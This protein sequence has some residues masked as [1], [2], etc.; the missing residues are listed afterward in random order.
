MPMLLEATDIVRHFPVTRGVILAREIGAVH[1]LDGVSFSLAAGKTLGLVGESGSGK[2]TAAKVVL[3]L[4]ELTSGRIRF[5]GIDIA[6]LDRRAMRKLRARMQIVFQDPYES[7]NPRMRVG[8]IV[9]EPLLV[10]NA[11][12][13]TGLSGAE[14]RSRTL[15]LLRQVGLDAEFAIRYPHQLSSGQRQRVG[16][17]RALAPGPKLVVCDEPVSALDVSIQAQILDLLQRLQAELGLA[18]LFISHDL[19]VV[20]QIA[21][22][23]AVMYLGKVVEDGD[24]ASVYR[25]PNHPYTQ[26]LLSAVPIPDPLAKRGG[27][28]ILLR[29]EI[30]S[31]TQPPSGCRF[32]TRCPIAERVCAEEE[33]GLDSVAGDH[34]VACHFAK[35]NPIPV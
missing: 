18:Y 21:D 27:K 35:V 24:I 7:L 17:A 16:I 19:A 2:S 3:R 9:A 23:V 26:A 30:P 13:E 29:G 34:R 12:G 5:E 33:P 1:A 11:A 10:S 22:R 25:T 8:D 6:A 15:E 32:R 28:R 4:I 20:R 31:A 14:I